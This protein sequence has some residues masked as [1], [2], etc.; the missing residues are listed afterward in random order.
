[1]STRSEQGAVSRSMFLLALRGMY[2]YAADGGDLSAALLSNQALTM[3]LDAWRDLRVDEIGPAP[4]VADAVEAAWL[5][6]HML[7]PL[8]ATPVRADIVHSSMNGLATLVGM[9]AKWQHGPPL[10]M[11]E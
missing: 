1:E 4:T 11:S 10:G 5:I 6:E 7:R 2:E 3:T 9:T 8:S